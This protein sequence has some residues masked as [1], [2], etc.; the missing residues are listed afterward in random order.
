MNTDTKPQG[1]GSPQCLCAG[2]GPAASQMLRSMV[3]AAADEHF[4]AAGIEFLKG[5]R[6]LIDHSIQ[7]MAQPAAKGTKIDIE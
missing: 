7:A 3:P 6:A 2:T 5:W 4:R 1:C